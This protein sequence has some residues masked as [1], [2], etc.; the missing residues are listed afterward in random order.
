MATRT[1]P[2]R[3]RSSADMMGR[4][5]RLMVRSPSL[6]LQVHRRRQAA[7]PP[8]RVQACG[9][10]CHDREPYRPHDAD[11]IKMRDLL[12]AAAV[13]EMGAR[14]QVVHGGEPQSCQHE[15]EGCAGDRQGT[16]LS[17]VLREDLPA[18]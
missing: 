11:G 3:L 8:G 14:V 1:A 15:P 5:L 16:D 2:V 4:T 12:I 17:E 10:G 7:D 6:A 13:A 9:E 18:A